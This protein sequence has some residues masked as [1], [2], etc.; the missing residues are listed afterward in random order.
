MQ[1]VTS[2]RSL[3]YRHSDHV[4]QPVHVS[5]VLL[6]EAQLPKSEQ[7]PKMDP[8]NQSKPSDPRSDERNKL[9]ALG[10]S[11]AL[12][13]T[14]VGASVL[15]IGLS[16]GV[17]GIASSIAGYLAATRSLHSLIGTNSEKPR[18]RADVVTPAMLNRDYSRGLSLGVLAAV[19]VVIYGSMDLPNLGFAVLAGML[20]GGSL[21]GLMGR[22][23]SSPIVS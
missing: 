7:T 5:S 1:E 6:S 4:S 11:H 8:N 3:R 13:S 22:N 18:A 23:A 20:F 10:V 17:W 9:S 12:L 2:L 19:P 21:Y 15:Y 16:V 14:G